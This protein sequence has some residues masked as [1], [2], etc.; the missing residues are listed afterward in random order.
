MKWLNSHIGRYKQSG[1]DKCTKCGDLVP[2][3]TIIC[4]ECYDEQ[5][6]N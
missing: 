6:L 2:Q 3:S 1:M 5:V 4:N